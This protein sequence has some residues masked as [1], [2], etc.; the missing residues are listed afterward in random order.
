MTFVEVLGLLGLA[1]TFYGLVRRNHTDGV[2]VVGLSLA[3][4]FVLAA[5]Y[6][7]EL[8]GDLIRQSGAQ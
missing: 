1:G 8:L 4:L 7:D 2:W 3:L 5:L 6:G